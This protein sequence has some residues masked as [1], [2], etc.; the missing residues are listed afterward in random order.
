MAPD[1]FWSFFKMSWIEKNVRNHNWSQSKISFFMPVNYAKE[2]LRYINI[3]ALFSQLFASLKYK[4]RTVFESIT[5]KSFDLISSFWPDLPKNH[6]AGLI[7]DN[8][9]HPTTYIVTRKKAKIIG[10]LFFFNTETST[11]S[12]IIIYGDCKL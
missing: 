9:T 6:W 10:R 4:P 5:Q 12:Q 2:F 1:I 7:G 3:E 8:P 11:I